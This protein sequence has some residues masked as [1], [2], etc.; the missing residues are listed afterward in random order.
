MAERA[1]AAG[2]LKYIG[3]ELGIRYSHI[4]AKLN[5]RVPSMM[6]RRD[7]L[8]AKPYPMAQDLLKLVSA[9][10]APPVLSGYSLNPL[11]QREAMLQE[12]VERGR[13]EL[14]AMATGGATEDDVL[15]AAKKFLS[16]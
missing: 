16:V 2:R 5:V 1:Y 3:D 12:Q 15:V 8:L 11:Q 13:D 7:G 10:Q 6:I 14:V 9:S 4:L